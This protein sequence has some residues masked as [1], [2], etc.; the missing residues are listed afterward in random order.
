[1][2][3]FS[4]F[5][6]LRDHFR[7]S[8]YLC[9]IDQCKD[10]QFTNVFSSETDFRA[11][12]AAQ[13]SKNRAHARQLG[14]LAVEFQSTSMRDRRQQRDPAHRG[15]HSFLILHFY[16]EF[17]RSIQKWTLRYTRK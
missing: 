12:Q 4:D 8:H 11:H 9:E 13:H 2:C 7:T 10:V 15:M 14:T 5:D 16:L 6:L 3:C 17:S 1:M